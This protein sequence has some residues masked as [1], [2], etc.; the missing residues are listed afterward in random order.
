VLLKHISM[1]DLAMVIPGC[2]AGWG[3]GGGR[4]GFGFCFRARHFL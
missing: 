2:G 1:H 3:T 4:T